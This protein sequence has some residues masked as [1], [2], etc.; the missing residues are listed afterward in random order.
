MSNVEPGKKKHA[1]NEPKNEGTKGTSLPLIQVVV[2]CS[3]S[4]E[5]ILLVLELSPKR[6]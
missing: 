2:S 6:A 4:K 3:T 1:N 5:G